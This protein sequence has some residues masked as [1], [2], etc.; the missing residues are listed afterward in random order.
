MRDT[1]PPS[2]YHCA[3]WC[4]S[5]FCQNLYAKAFLLLLKTNS[6]QTF[7]FAR[8]LLIRKLLRLPCRGEVHV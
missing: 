6:P 1:H 5:Y 4:V 3:L 2:V 7:P 8:I